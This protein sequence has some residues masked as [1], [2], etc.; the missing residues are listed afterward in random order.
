MAHVPGHRWLMVADSD[1]LP[2][3]GG[4]ERE[5]LG[6]A[7][8]ALDAGWLA[9]VVLP[10]RTTPDLAAYRD[11]LGD[12]P[13]ITTRRRTSPLML[14]HPRYPYVVASRPFR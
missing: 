1:F 10:V 5:H 2:A 14:A 9:A 8:A 3:N 4:G 7:R 13:L 11:L 6:F 12:V